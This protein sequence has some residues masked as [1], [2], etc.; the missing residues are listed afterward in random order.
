VVVVSSILYPVSENITIR[1]YTVKVTTAGVGVIISI[2]DV[3]VTVAVTVARERKAEQKE[4]AEALILPFSP[5]IGSTQL[6]LD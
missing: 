3:V 4:F 1:N 5:R 6:V 2:P